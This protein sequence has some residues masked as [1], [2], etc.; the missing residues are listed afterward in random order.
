MNFTEEQKKV[1]TTRGGN[2]LVSASAGSGKTTVMIERILSLLLD[3]G[4]SLENM[5]ICTFTRAA[6]A[7]M[8][9]KLQTV[10][11]EK[12]NENNE[13]AQRQLALLPTAEISTM[14]SWCQRLIKTYFY[15]IGADPAFELLDENE[16]LS[17]KNEAVS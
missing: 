17:L 3:D 6:A 14:H 8:R 11:M 2:L 4:V 5:V 16:A 13:I 1:I 12:A 7:D 9:E 15:A 10:L